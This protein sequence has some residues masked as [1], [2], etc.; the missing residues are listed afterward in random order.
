MKPIRKDLVVI[1][2]ST[3][4]SATPQ[5]DPEA[6]VVRQQF[7]TQAGVGYGK[8]NNG[9][10]GGLPAIVEY[11]TQ[12]GEF[13]NAAKSA[14]GVCRH[15]DK[16]SW[17]KHLSKTEGPLGSK[18]DR[19]TLNQMRGR[20]M[21]AGYGPKDGNGEVDIE[22][23]LATFGVCRPLSDIIEGWVGKN[24]IHWPVLVSD[25]ANCPTYVQAEGH[26]TEIVTPAAPFGLFK[27]LDLDARKVGDQRRDLV[28]FTAAGKQPR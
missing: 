21:M 11:R 12:A 15:F 19:E 2:Q 1:G 10:L 17:L 13:A 6:Q 26:R 14:C 8:D 20:L 28:L 22:A 23:A 9:G 18:E 5:T 24:P 25:S 27:P 4:V 16:R 3:D 7:H